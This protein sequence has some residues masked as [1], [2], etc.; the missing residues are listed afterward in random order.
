MSST[1]TIH[2]H[3][4]DYTLKN[5]VQLVHGGS[6]YFN[7]LVSLID[8]AKDVIHLQVYI[9]TED[10]TGNTI[11]DALIRAANRKVK[12][13]LLVDGFASQ[14]LS[15]DFKNK[16]QQSGIN[17][18]M[19]EPIFK[20]SNFYFGRRLHHKVI[21]ADHTV[22]M[23]GGINIQNKYND[24]GDTKAWFDMALSVKGE[25]AIQ[26]SR[27]C[28]DIWNGGGDP[29]EKAQLPVKPDIASLHI[30]NDCAVRVRR[31]DWVK[32][33][34]QIWKSYFNMLNHSTEEI[35]IASSY[36]LPGMIFRQRMAGAIS[37]GVCI[38]VII[39]GPSD[40]PI[41]KSAE[42]YLYRWM[43]RNG[44]ELYEYTK[45]IL[46][47]KV[48]VADNKRLTIGSYNFN[49]LSAYASI[50]LNLDVRNKPF[51]STVQQELND[52]I[53]NDCTRITE[54]DYLDNTSLINKAWQYIAYLLVKMLLSVITFYY[55]Q[56]KRY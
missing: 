26:L 49:N 42:K 19:F 13:F 37:R 14:D 50:E 38:K 28:C 41:A 6:E 15:D 25:T 23:V 39:A 40:V 8:G 4:R 17:F 36:F 22:A 16:L 44:I 12:V 10:E 7:K 47:A 51:V 53:K 2:K 45:S 9:F 46:H 34:M 55:T 29:A 5:K 52:V 27:I 48:S 56:E 54:E 3:E 33:K 30:N 32:R 43:L 35:I 18:R 1:E 24:V 31:N 20:S 21:V 11:A